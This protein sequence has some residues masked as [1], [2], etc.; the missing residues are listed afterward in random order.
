MYT[1]VQQQQ[2]MKKTRFSKAGQVSELWLAFRRDK[3]DEYDYSRMKGA[4]VLS[5]DNDEMIGIVYRP[6][7]KQTNAAYSAILVCIQEALGDHPKQIYYGAADEVLSVLKNDKLS[8]KEKKK[9]IVPLL[10]NM[11][12]ERYK[13][14]LTLSHK[15]TDYGNDDKSEASEENMDEANVISV[16]FENSSEDEEEDMNAEVVESDKESEGEEAHGSGTIHAGNVRRLS[17]S[18]FFLF[19]KF[20]G[21]NEFSEI[22]SLLLLHNIYCFSKIQ[23]NSNTTN[24]TNPLIYSFLLSVSNL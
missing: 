13:D 4:S 10:E 18:F 3:R 16:T 20:D 24:L 8:E 14:L 1:R 22:W 21:I 23:L 15:I 17:V 2:H 12:E 9:E 11:P 5:E 19:S 7:T 6:K